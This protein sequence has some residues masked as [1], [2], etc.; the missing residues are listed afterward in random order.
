[1]ELLSLLLWHA[2]G[3]IGTIL[4]VI[5]FAWVADG[6]EILLYEVCYVIFT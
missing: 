4:Y 1:M 6:A 5:E 2:T 3:Q